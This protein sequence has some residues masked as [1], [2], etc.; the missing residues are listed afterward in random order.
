FAATLR[1]LLPGR[2]RILYFQCDRFHAVA[3]LKNVIRNCMLRPKRCSQNEC[4]LVLP[5]H[6]AGALSHTGFRSAIS[7]RLKTERTLIKM[8]RLLGV[9]DVKFDVICSFER[10]KIF[11]HRWG[12]FL[13]WSSNCRWHNFLLSI[14]L[15]DAWSKYKIDDQ[16]SQGCM[17]PHPDPT[18]SLTG[19]TAF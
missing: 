8:R 12:S 6:I 14:S 9:T 3:V 15:A 13:F 2:S 10:Q 19:A 7:H 4:D 1:G 18:K 11:L 16:S 5:D 17:R